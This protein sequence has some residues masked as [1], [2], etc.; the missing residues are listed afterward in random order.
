MQTKVR[1][2]LL[3]ALTR[4]GVLEPEYAEVM[5]SWGHGGG[6]SV[7]AS[8][9]LEGADR[10]GLERLRRRSPGLRDGALG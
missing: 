3:R 8:V 4:R 2:R 6:F 9:R 10:Q 1:R 5:A 7:D